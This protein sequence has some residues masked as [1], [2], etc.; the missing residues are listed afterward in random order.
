MFPLQCPLS[1]EDQPSIRGGVHKLGK[2]AAAQ[3]SMQL[4][5]KVTDS[6]ASVGA[7]FNLVGGCASF[8]LTGRRRR[9]IITCLWTL[10]MLEVSKQMVNCFGATLHMIEVL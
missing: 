5:F 6:G 3:D 1:V 9:S 10:Q 7:S 4:K 8:I 2:L